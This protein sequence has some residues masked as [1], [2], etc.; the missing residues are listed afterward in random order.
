MR[1]G[2]GDVDDVARLLA[3]RLLGGD[4]LGLFLQLGL[5]AVAQF[6]E[7]V[8]HV[9]LLLLRHFLEAREEGRDQAAFAAEV[10]DAKV[11]ERGGRVGGCEGGVEFGADACDV[12]EHG[13]RAIVQTKT[14]AHGPRF[15]CESVMTFTPTPA[16]RPGA[17]LRSLCRARCE[18]AACSAHPWRSRRWR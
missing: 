15:Q 6:V 11:I 8:A 9:L 3:R 14:R 16:S 18:A 5:E 4:A 1:G 10:V 7:R 17:S 2:E 12:V 13:E